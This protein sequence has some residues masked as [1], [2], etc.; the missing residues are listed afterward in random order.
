MQLQS[1]PLT[2]HSNI[3]LLQYVKKN[4][5]KVT[6]N[7]CFNDKQNARKDATWDGELEKM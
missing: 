5:W 1:A 4:I 6:S 7:S 3:H 2:K